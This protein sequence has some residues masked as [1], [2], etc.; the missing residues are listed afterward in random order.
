MHIPHATRPLVKPDFSRP[1]GRIPAK[2]SSQ[3]LA[4]AERY[5]ESVYRP[6]LRARTE[7]N[8]SVR[9]LA[10]QAVTRLRSARP[11]AL[12]VRKNAAAKD[13]TASA[14]ADRALTCTRSGD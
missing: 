9:S 5:Q 10:D 1:G 7:R 13:S 11:M 8:Q 4:M 6:V 3:N 12:Y 14:L 2:F